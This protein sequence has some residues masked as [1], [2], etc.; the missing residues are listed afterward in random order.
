MKDIK[1][2]TISVRFFK[3]DE[4]ILA[5]FGDRSNEKNEW[6]CYAR[7]GQHG[8]AS[9]SYVKSLKRAKPIEYYSL[10]KEIRGIYENAQFDD[11]IVILKIK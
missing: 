2:S 4:D 10:L 9:E 11:S 6:E 5:V 8:H 3:E 1:V 7:T